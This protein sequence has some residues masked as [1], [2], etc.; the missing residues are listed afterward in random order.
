LLSADFLLLG[1]ELRLEIFIIDLEFVQ[2]VS[3]R[4][5]VC[6]VPIVGSFSIDH[7]VTVDVVLMSSDQKTVAV[8]QCDVLSEK[9]AIDLDRVLVD[10][11]LI[12]NHSRFALISIEIET[13]LSVGDTDTLDSDLRLELS[14]RFAHKV[15]A[16]IH[17]ELDHAA[18]LWILVNVT[19]LRRGLQLAFFALSLLLLLMLGRELPFELGLLNG[20]SCLLLPLEFQE[21]LVGDTVTFWTTRTTRQAT[22]LPQ[23]L[24]FFAQLSDQFILR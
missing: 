2:L 6:R 13:A 3:I 4:F 22:C 19:Q 14:A 5:F 21:L 16:F 15:V 12:W 9:I 20:E 11:I 1:L 7:R 23:F 10:I 24:D 18:H 17:R 8:L